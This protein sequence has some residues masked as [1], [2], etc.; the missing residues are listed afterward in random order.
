MVVLVTCKTEENPPKNKDTRVATT[1]LQ[2]KVYTLRAT[3]SSVCDR[4]WLKF[5]IQL[6]IMFFF[7][8]AIDEED[9]TKN[10]TAGVA[11]TPDSH[12]SNTQ[13]HLS[14]QLYMLK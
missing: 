4:I 12:F 2:L 5:E 3:N 10:E 6:Y 8:A 11:T 1:F 7:I 14:L 9:S 13:G